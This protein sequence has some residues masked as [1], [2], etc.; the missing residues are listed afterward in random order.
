MARMR[1]CAAVLQLGRVQLPADEPI[2]EPKEAIM[3]KSV[4]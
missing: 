4:G 3:T 1:T 2:I